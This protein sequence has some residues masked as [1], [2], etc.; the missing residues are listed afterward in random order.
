MSRKSKN[1]TFQDAD[2]PQEAISRVEQIQGKLIRAKRAIVRGLPVPSETPA[3]R[4]LFAARQQMLSY[5][6]LIQNAHRSTADLELLSERIIGENDLLPL[7]FLARGMRASQSVA[8]LFTMPTGHGS[9]FLVSPEALIT[10]HHVIKTP[11]AAY[12]TQV[13]LEIHDANGRHVE[14]RSCELEPERFWHTDSKLDFS[15]VALRKSGRSTNGAEG[16]G[17]HPMISQQGKIRIGDPVNIIQH[18]GGRSKT[19]AMHNS[20]LL[21]LEDHTDLSAFIWYSCDTDPGS[22]GSPVFNNRWEVIGVH[23]RSVPRTNENGEILDPKGNVI[24]KVDFDRDPKRAAWIA[25][26]GVRTSRI[27]SALA[28]AT[29]AREVHGLFRDALLALWEQSRLRNHGQEAVQVSRCSDPAA[30]IDPSVNAGVV[31]G[32]VTIRITIEPG[33]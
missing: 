18:P 30:E 15:I 25:N 24:P 32:P 10:N 4:E 8:R 27:V 14:N 9:G 11:E 5:G 16:L 20:N 33:T 13:V 21:H 19:I 28:E 1:A 12:A 3:R 26:Q 29:F 22:S 17:W 6:D 2:V 7:D 31:R 23:H